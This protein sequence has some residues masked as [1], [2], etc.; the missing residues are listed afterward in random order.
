MAGVRNNFIQ[1]V[2]LLTLCNNF[3]QIFGNLFVTL[4]T[5]CGRFDTAGIDLTI[6]FLRAVAD[7]QATALI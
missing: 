2:R 7:T 6:D 5:L 1:F 3:V 4:L